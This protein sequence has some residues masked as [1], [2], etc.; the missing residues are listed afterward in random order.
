M[1]ALVAL[2]TGQWQVLPASDGWHIVRLDNFVPGRKVDLS[3]V[4]AQAAQTWKDERR[5]IL[6]IAA[7]RDLG[8]A[9]V[10][11]RGEP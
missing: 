8:K 4:S 7:T 2:P 10:I 5:R 1:D 11:R 6:A 9:Y 3:E